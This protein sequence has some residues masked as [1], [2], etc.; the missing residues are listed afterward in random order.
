MTAP[1]ISVTERRNAIRKLAARKAVE[2]PLLPSGFWFHSDIRDN[3]YYAIHLFASSIEGDMDEGMPEEQRN[4]AN[5]LAEGMIHNVL[6]L[7]VQDPGHPM[8]GHWPLGL[9]DNPAAAKPHPLPVELMGC[10]LIL[11]YNKY[12]Q[13][14]PIELKSDLSIAILHMYQSDVYRHPLK[15]I[16]HHEAKHTALKL[17]LGHQFDD[18]ELLESGLASLKQQ[19]HHIR[20]FGF[21]EYGCL[22]WHWHWI[23]AFTCVWEVVDH[24]ETRKTVSKMLDCLWDIRAD[25]YLKG[26]WVGA[27]SR[28]WP[29]DAP[30]D[31]NTLLDYIAFG[32]FPE[33]AAITRL[34]GA[35][36][37][38]YEVAEA[39]VKKAVHRR[40][41]QEVK[42]KIRFAG[43]DRTVTEEAHTY[44][45]ITPDYATGGIWERRD[46]FDNEQ[47]RWDVTFPLTS[48]A[49]TGGNNINQA[50]FFHPG[51]KY[52]AG[53]DRHASP[54]GEVLFH[55]DSMIQLWAIPSS[56]APDDIYPEIVGCLPKGDWR[57]Q[58]QSGYGR[59]G[60]V[61]MAFHLM[62]EWTYTEKTDRISISSPLKAG[63]NG[64]VV[65]VV[66]CHEAAALGIDSLEKLAESMH[67]SKAAYTALPSEEA[68]SKLQVHY[69]TRR[70][71]ILALT[72]GPEGYERM[73][74][75]EPVNLA[76]Y[77]VSP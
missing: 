58:D 10:L 62:N 66:S 20:E 64:V 44:V 41:P 19:L 37:Y 56:T 57:F 23:Q 40:L 52:K 22:P 2:L 1:L 6:K 27:Q 47:Q 77:P 4:A 33:P 42:R 72:I 14:L 26:T 67:S 75:G 17:L 13:T 49:I 60:D 63:L 51:V 29:H 3:F 69:R 30:L 34:E 48:P 70:N 55:L 54:Y 21:K 32:D 74:N 53:D 65:E 36:L 5:N 9:G 16:H 25:Y 15:Q 11:F 61:Y 8:Y 28:Q 24:P 73:I 76:D 50:L 39:I 45:Y 38:T 18:K 46:E 68:E 7:Q 59:I 71:D 35:A 31:N 43:A 12:Q